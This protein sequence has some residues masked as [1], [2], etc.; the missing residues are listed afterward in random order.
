MMA[1]HFLLVEFLKILNVRPK[2]SIEILNRSLNYRHRALK[3]VACFET[4]IV[5]KI[6]NKINQITEMV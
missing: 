3:A 2:N 1:M 5:Q 6:E 4:T